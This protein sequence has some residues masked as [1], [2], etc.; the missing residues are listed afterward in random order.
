VEQVENS[1]SGMENKVEELD[2]TVRDHERKYEWNM[3]DIWDTMK[4]PNL[5]II[6]VEEGEEIQT[7]E[8]FQRITAE[9]S[10]NLKKESVIQVQ[11]VYRTTNCQDQKRNTP[12]YIIIK[13]LSSQNKRILK[14]TKK[15]DKSHIKANPLE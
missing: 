13:T 5:W 9:K 7:K 14:A 8:L 4:R 2:Q 10:P 15:K 12:R 11:E 1:V 3:Q 6:G